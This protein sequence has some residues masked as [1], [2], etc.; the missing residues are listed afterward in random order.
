M[1]ANEWDVDV[2][3]GGGG[4][5]GLVLA[6]ELGRRGVR[7]VLFND[8]PDTTPYPQAGATQART[9][10]HYRRLGL[11]QQIRAAG[12]PPDYPT[13][14]AY[15]TR[16]TGAELT[17]FRL[18]SSGS[19][20]RI[21]RDLGGSWSAAELPHRCSQMFIERI[22][23]DEARKLPSVELNFGWRVTEFTDHSGHVAVEA[24]GP[25]GERRSVTAHYLVG[26]DGARSG[27][28]RQ[29]G[30]NY[31]GERMLD[32]PFL[33][34][35]MYAIY[36]KSPEVYGLIPHERSWQYW[37]I[38]A[39]RRGM[40]LALDGQDGFVFMTQLRPDEDPASMSEEHVAGL[41]HRAMG[42]PFALRIVARSPWT[43]GLTLVAERFRAGRVFLGGDAAHLFTPTGGL[44]YNTAVEDAVNLGW[45]LAAVVKGYAAPELL[46]SYERERQAV[47]VR[48]TGY[49]RMFAESIG[50]LAVPPNIEDDSDPGADAARVSTGA[51]LLKHA[52]AEFN[53]PGIT[54]GARY[55]GSP[56]I[57]HDGTL[58]PADSASVYEPTACPGGRAPHQWLQDG[59]S[60][61]DA[62]GFEFTLLVLA[63]GGSKSVGSLQRAAVARGVPL[64][65]LD[66]SSEP[67]LRDLYQAD[68]ALIRPDQIVCWRGNG[69]PMDS[70]R[71]LSQVTGGIA[72]A[73]G[74]G[75]SHASGR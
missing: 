72:A 21:I 27:I 49:A 8:R 22:L 35:Q 24:E 18:P 20:S 6:H 33:A 38:N 1:V 64:S 5:C 13:D 57:V 65:V 46:D 69:M 71:L 42:R 60:L 54:L 67:G 40:M 32:R 62:F 30:I 53:I 15:F 59:R 16:L 48:N 28:R 44:G 66:L 9:M 51:A 25:G 3:I 39:E 23:H 56:I 26:V 41:L 10:E 11:S 12:L 61:Y 68:F 17:R 37:V 2:V 43:A 14:V 47:A 19:A 75:R 70:E 58:P 31:Q 74:I 7:V 36:F 45:K 55:D 4:P 73:A 52:Q 29:L 34:G 63:H 50:R